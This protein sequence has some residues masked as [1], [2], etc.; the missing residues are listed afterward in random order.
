M[1]TRA[2]A[3]SLLSA[4]NLPATMGGVSKQTSES[5][6]PAG[7]SDVEGGTWALAEPFRQSF[8]RW[9][10]DEH[11]ACVR[12]EL[13]KLEARAQAGEGDAR[14]ELVDAFSRELP[15]GT[16]GR[17]GPVG[18][19]PNRMNVV[20]LQET[21]YGLCLAMQAQGDVP[22]VVL[23]YDTRRESR[24]FAH[25]AARQIAGFGMQALLLDAPRSTPE[26]SFMVRHLSCG[27]GI[28]IS[29]SHNPPGDN[30]IKIY[31]PDGAQVLGERDATLMKM[32]VEKGPQAPA[33]VAELV[34]RDDHGQSKVPGI[35]FVAVEIEDVAYANYVK[36]QALLQ[37]EATMSQLRMTFTPL[38][39]VGHTIVVPLLRDLG[40]DVRPVEAQC[41]PDGGRFS[42]V[43]SA[44]PE[45]PEAFEMA[46]K[47]AREIDADLAVATDPDAD[48]MGA[49]ARDASGEFAFLDGNRLAVVLLEHVLAHE[50]KRAENW[51]VTTMV[52]T[53]LLRKMARA[54]D[55]DIVDDLQV[56]FKHHAAMV[57]EEPHRRLILACE[58]SHGYCRGTGVRD[59]DGAC[60]VLLLAEAAA[61][62]KSQGHSL[63]Q[64]LRRVWQRF[65][66]HREITRSIQASGA[67]GREKI[68]KAMA[69]WRRS[70]PEELAGLKRIAFR[71]CLV[72]GTTSSPTR[73]LVG[74]VIA[75]E[76]GAGEKTC[77]VVLRPSG[78]EPKIKFYVLIGGGAVE[79]QH[80]DREIETIDAL[81][82][83]V[84]DAALDAVRAAMAS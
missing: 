16:G 7:R 28:M 27:A 13:L 44:N 40:V 67:S 65:G 61:H 46:L 25:V 37:S 43:K 34:E 42:T 55:V 51:V 81:A 75:L 5:A 1:K 33:L 11:Y 30:G 70:P 72:P 24:F 21:V 12:D 47:L 48:R 56:G 80:L 8:E 59:K 2:C 17:R 22:R 77:R 64:V 58:E 82:K 31:G 3:A 38:H 10:V 68:A 18:P 83:R 32:I 79:S 41:D 76:F 6:N 74:D 29:A 60:A 54:C 19:G 84:A 39:G 49:F 69:A 35:A 4:S 66:Y 71:D 52:T 53:P 9:I 36:Q 50:P 26:L 45:A 78:T 62:A 63:W 73:N 57:A 20:T 14:D 23:T 15:I